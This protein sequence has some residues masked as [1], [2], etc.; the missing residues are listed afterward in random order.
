MVSRL[1]VLLT[2]ACSGIALVAAVADEPHQAIA[3]AVI[4]HLVVEYLIEEWATAEWAMPSPD[5]AVPADGVTSN[6]VAALLRYRLTN[7][8]GGLF[9]TKSV[10]PERAERGD[11]VAYQITVQNNRAGLARQV[12][13]VDDLPPGFRYVDGSA[14]MGADPIP[15]PAGGAGP[16]LVF[17]LPGGVPG[18]TSV[19]LSYTVQIG[20]TAGL[21][22]NVNHVVAR[23]HTDDFRLLL[24][25]IARAEV[26]VEAARV[27]R[28]EAT[29]LGTV[30]LD[31]DGD[32]VQRPGA[33]AGSGATGAE[34]GVPGVRIVFE[35][36]AA[37]TT[38][39]FGRYSI[40]GFTARTHVAAIDPVTLPT[41]ARPQVTG[42]RQAFA[43]HARLLDL[44]NGELHR[45]DFALGPCT[46]AVR[47]AVTAR[48]DRIAAF[49]E[50]APWDV[51]LDREF[52]DDLPA[53]TGD[54]PGDASTQMQQRAAADRSGPGIGSRADGAGA[55]KRI[56]PTRNLAADIETFDAALAFI[57]LATGDAL[58]RLVIPVRV[59]GMA[60]A[61]IVLVVNGEEI[62]V[63]RIGQEVVWEDGGSA[64]Y[65]YV[66]VALQPGANTLE[67]RQFDGFGIERERTAITVMAPGDPV[68]LAIDAPDEAVADGRSPVPIAV[69]L[70]DEHGLVSPRQAVVTLATTAGRFA[71]TDIEPSIRGVQALIDDGDTL[72]ALIPPTTAGSQTVSIETAFGTFAKT[73]S[74]VPDLRP[75]MAVGVIE[76]AM[77]LGGG[78]A[79]QHLFD[80]DDL[81]PF[82]QTQQGVNGALYLKGRMR[83]DYLLTLAYDS[84]REPRE[85]LFRDLRPHEFHPVYG[86]ES[87][88]AFDAQ[89]ASP[90]YARVAKDH[91]SVLYGDFATAEHQD[92]RQLGRYGRHL[93]GAKAHLEPR[94]GAVVVDAFVAYVDYRQ[95]VVELRPTGVSGPY[96]LPVDGAIV[97]GSERVE[98][99]IRDRERPSVV[100]RTRLLNRGEDYSLGYFVDESILFNRP[101]AAL[102]DELNPQFIRIT[103]EQREENG[104]ADRYPIFGGGARWR[105]AEGLSAGVGAA[106]AEEPDNQLALGSVWMESAV[107]EAGTLTAELALSDA[108]QQGGGMAGRIVYDHR[109]E[110]LELRLGAAEAD[111]SF[112]TPDTFVV[113]GQREL[114]AEARVRLAKAVRLVAAGVHTEGAASDDRH[115]EVQAGLEVKAATGLRID[116]GGRLQQEG[117]R[118]S[119]AALVGAAWRPQALPDLSLEAEYEHGLLADERRLGAGVA[120]D[121][122]GA[123]VY[124]RHEIHAAGGHT[125]HTTVVGS[126][127]R[128]SE[129]LT[130]FVELR[131][132]PPTAPDADA[133]TELAAGVR[134]A[135]TLVDGLHGEV[136]L[137][138]VT[139]LVSGDP[140]GAAA[141]V[142][143]D[144]EHPG[145]AWAGRGSIEWSGAEDGNHS[146]HGSLG[147]AYRIDPNWSALLQNRLSIVHDGPRGEPVTD[148]RLRAGVAWRP[149]QHNRFNAL[150]WYEWVRTGS[151][152]APGAKHL[153]SVKADYR[154]L[155][156][157]VVNGGYAG[158]WS[159]QFGT[160]APEA[161]LLQQVSVRLRYDLTDRFDVGIAG[162]TL[163][164]GAVRNPVY[165][166][167]IEGG[168]VVA[169][170]LRAALGYNVIG[171]HE[172]DL[173]ADQA[174]GVYVRL[175]AMVDERLFSWLQ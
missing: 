30:F 146:W 92:G 141:F 54:Q 109:S 14:R 112:T 17:A 117:E 12:R 165:R 134:G 84:D 110:D 21:G 102:D 116:V 131:A 85:P 121:F 49:A 161:S 132:E 44:R 19:A 127:Y 22:R 123:E 169:E 158:K 128:G 62:P 166:F 47:E 143:L 42:N 94:D 25:D 130:S 67:L 79:I 18:G 72:F 27:F 61:R 101:I 46:S 87:Q 7:D 154:P 70:I 13:V 78:G 172:E 100:L 125:E 144:Y 162:S 106:V 5:A 173:G 111:A 15:D 98:L 95:R 37:T 104:P 77:R 96:R 38:D 170:N 10:N 160:A 159:G 43:A 136:R 50:P 9:I 63:D 93:T 55:Q 32:G 82:E 59:K 31:C 73:I 34:P 167:G 142:A 88:P 80:D 24:S 150:G 175:Q 58:K 157:L 122:G 4:S 152:A 89:S 1:R 41:G 76:G 140:T 86:D 120:Y 8:H 138:R 75:M 103:F 36:G 74:F 108:E 163:F 11:A 35:N 99:V 174:A 45:A 39:R 40:Y 148:N 115:T 97:P 119:A 145:G 155:R 2:A 60:Y 71:A 68:R 20:S 3:P 33:A 126:E 69:R 81:S 48:I 156:Q 64:A 91:S 57:E 137:E 53:L 65:E 114:Q 83:G 135:H 23:G 29:V 151:A 26:L 164:E 16:R 6:T 168:L 118:T 51:L 139:D 124:A 105:A 147:A 28:E 107:G 113:A 56:A 52:V 153:W 129:H 149:V 171:Y 133:A 66:A 90:L